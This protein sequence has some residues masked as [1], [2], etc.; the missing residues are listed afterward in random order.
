METSLYKYIL[1]HSKRD[2]ILLI[3]LSVSSL[4]LVYITLEL[5]KKIINLLEGMDIPES[6][7][8]YEFDR[9]EFLMIFS[10]AFLLTVLC[11][12]GLKYLL[13]VYRGALGERLLRRF[14][15]E[16]YARIL[17]F[18]MPHFKRVSS[19]E[20]IPMITAETEPLGEFIGESYTL[21]VFQGGILITYLFFIFQQDLFLGLAA[22]SLYPF[23]LYVIPRLQKRVNELA[24]ERVSTVR[25]LSGRIG[26]TVT[27]I[28]EVHAN[29]TSHYERAHISQRLG[30]IYQIRFDIYKRKFFIKFLN[31]FI[32]QLTPFFFYSVGGYFVL[33]G[34]LSIGSM[35]A[36]LVAYKDLSG[37]W[38]ELLRYYQRKED[39]KV[40]YTQVIQQFDPHNLIEA[41]ILDHQ[42]ELQQLP[43]NEI[44]ANNLRYT[45]DGLYYSI[46]GA[47][48]RIPTD[49][50]CA[51]VGLGNSGKDELAGLVS[52]LI[53]PSSG[54]LTIGDQKMQELPE[55]ITGKRLGYVGPSAFMF[56]GTVH[57]NLCYSLKHQPVSSALD[58]DDKALQHERQMAEQAGNSP[59][60]YDDEWID[61]T[62]LGMDSHEELVERII[63][64]L[65]CVDLDEEIY[66]F[67]LLSFVDPS[68][69][70][71][72]AERIM[73]A[74]Q[75][76]RDKFR[77]P[78]IARLVEP[79]DHE[80][81]N[82][83]MT[84][85]ENLLFGTV[86]GHK[87]ETESMID[88]PV[89][90]EVLQEVGLTDTFLEA[91]AKITEI[92]L[93][94]F[95]DVEPD[96]ELFEQFSFISA[97]DLPE[98][99][100]LLQQTRQQ[101]LESLQKDDQ[102]RLM[103][104]PF[105]LIVARHRLGLITEP[106]Q[107]QI[108]D[109]RARIHEIA[110]TQDLGIEF[111]NEGSYNPRISIQDNI[112]FGKLAYGQAYAQQKINSLIADVVEELGLREDIIEV[113]LDYEVG[114]AGG[115]LSS[116]QRQK[117]GVARALLKAP[118]LLIVNGALSG[119]DTAGERRLIENIRQLMGTRGI[120][121]IL[122]RV[123]L[124]ELFDSVMVM[125]RGKLLDQ[126]SFEQLQSSN[127]HFKQLLLSE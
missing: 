90:R 55:A 63:E 89:I 61:Y 52:R 36:V 32:A 13:N 43:G 106:I 95:S 100:N 12:G 21:P 107:Q 103:S 126:G 101:E 74:R 113:G 48:F 45:E 56:N 123:Q 41:D 73:Q 86:Y 4:P 59:N 105:K 37:P 31:N 94:L 122:G 53:Y 91:G 85:S 108:L 1:M 39:V 79:F 38:K 30:K 44:L 10:F 111:F 5:P 47:S 119:L 104:L 15:Y 98:F 115:R 65:K 75:M 51:A 125:E 14:R 93:D 88:N 42:P 7:F 96:S 19:G 99:N 33:R 116:V 2:Q 67:G 9:L 77:Q 57:D 102:R 20:L 11:S 28:N 76:L 120:L 109:A 17:R 112:L 35:V 114:V 127:E 87:I 110:K 71:H 49:Q 18:P 97:D 82:L 83:N 25:N 60:R 46:D 8:G 24:K 29:D 80:K 23:Q 50:H 26:E 81:Y 69:H 72:L 84:V 16:L 34:D 70:A 27:G 124:A 92:M 62:S 118:D 121:W 6:L 78:D 64:I 117:L 22:I 40:K 3:L 54:N 58:S 68:Q 66:Q